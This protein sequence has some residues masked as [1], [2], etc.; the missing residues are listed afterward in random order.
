MI[1]GGLVQ[2]VNTVLLIVQTRD[3]ISLVRDD[4]KRGNFGELFGGVL[5]DWLFGRFSDGAE[6]EDR[7]VIAR[8]LSQRF[9]V[10]GD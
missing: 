9:H 7:W 4:K 10:F 3:W 8:R 1:R 5:F 2:P 6:S